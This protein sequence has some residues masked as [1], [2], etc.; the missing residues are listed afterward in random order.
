MSAAEAGKELE[1]T[2]VM[3]VYNEQ[4]CITEVVEAWREMLARTVGS[5]EMLVIDD[6]SKDA[7]WELLRRYAGCE[8]GRAEVRVRRKANSGHGPTVMEGYR[9]AAGESQWVFQVDSDD[10]LGPES[11]GA[12]WAR[13]EEF[14]LLLGVRTGRRSSPG[15]RLI[16]GVSRLTV[17]LMFGGWVRDANTPYRLMRAER[18][19]RHLRALPEDAF[20][21]NVI[22]TGLFVSSGARVC[23]MAVPYRARRT[24]TVSIVRWRLWRSAA[25]AFAQTAAV[26]WRGRRVSR[27][28]EGFRNGGGG[29]G[30]A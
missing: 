8:G 3:P 25:K 18:L 7:T 17:R 26:A 10:E 28:E 1:L 2:L 16:T 13:R 20:A 5:F 22:L 14:D 12:L 19:A 21:P 23:Q 30:A 6:G 24:G 4:G 9:E 15:R 29:D 11:F 27:G